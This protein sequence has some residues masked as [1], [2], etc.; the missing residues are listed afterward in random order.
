MEAVTTDVDAQRR[1]GLRLPG[2]GASY[3]ANPIG[4]ES[5]SRCAEATAARMVGHTLRT[6]AT[7][8]QPALF[9]PSIF[10]TAKFAALHWPLY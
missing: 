5:K 4:Q 1:L 8:L 10:L 2:N 7:R 6:A 9:F 3:R